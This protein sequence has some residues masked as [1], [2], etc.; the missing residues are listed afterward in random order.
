MTDSIGLYAGIKPFKNAS[1]P[2]YFDMNVGGT[3]FHSHN[4]P[5][6]R[7][8]APGYFTPPPK[9]QRDLNDTLSRST[10][11][12]VL[13]LVGREDSV[14]FGRCETSKTAYMYPS[15]GFARGQKMGLA[16]DSDKPVDG[17][18]MPIAGFYNINQSNVL[19]GLR[20]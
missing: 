17:P 15:Q 19:G 13:P 14:R 1:E 10:L 9:P 8:I 7:D 4:A 12:Q 5:V 11:A 2:G 20:S 18:V 3:S 16:T 6:V